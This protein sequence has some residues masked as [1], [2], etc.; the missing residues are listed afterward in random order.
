MGRRCSLK[1]LGPYR[2]V[3]WLSRLVGKLMM[4]M[5]SKGHFLG[6]IPQPIQRDSEMNASL[7]SGWTSI[8]SFPL[9]TTGQDFLHSCRHFR[10]RH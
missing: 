6:Q 3:T 8:Q 10:G 2:W 4:V 7:E 9:R 1:L 5:A